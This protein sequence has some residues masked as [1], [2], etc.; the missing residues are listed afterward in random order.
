[1]KCAA[2]H[3]EMVE[4]RG[5][6]D[7]RIG[8]RLHIVKDV[9]FKECLNCGERVISPETSDMLFRKI[10]EGEYVEQMIRLPVLN[11][12]DWGTSINK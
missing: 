10:E 7:L 5:E 6:I 12:T 1:M 8:G 9:S 3:H 11:G 2:C 4:K